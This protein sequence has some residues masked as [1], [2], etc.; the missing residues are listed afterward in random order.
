VSV[1]VESSSGR[2][3]AGRDVEQPVSDGLGCRAAKL[4]DAA[5]LLG[6]GEQVVGG[7]AALHPRVVVHD[8]I[9][10]Q[11]RESGRLGVADDVLGADAL[12]L[13]EL[14]GGDAVAGGVGDERG[15]PEPLNSV[16]QAELGAGRG[17]SRRTINRV[18]S[19]QASRFTRSVSSKTS[20]PSRRAPSASIAGC[21]QPVGTPM[22]PSRTR[23]VDL[24]AE[25][26]PDVAVDA[27]LGEPVRSTSAVGRIRR[28]V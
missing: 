20:A 6:P 11:A 1:E 17:R 22:T 15:V 21:Q 25:R 8:V 19:G 24:V 27:F 10:R 7:E 18:P 3:D 16:E 2:G 23:S 14:E 26:E 28:T 12:T 4:P 5:D 13:P 9:E